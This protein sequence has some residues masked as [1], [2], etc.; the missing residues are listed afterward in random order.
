LCTSVSITNEVALLLS[1]HKLFVLLHVKLGRSYFLAGY[2]FVWRIV[3]RH[4]LWLYSSILIVCCANSG[5][6]I[7]VT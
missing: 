6:P 7:G 1:L 3:L 2:V 4:S 5:L